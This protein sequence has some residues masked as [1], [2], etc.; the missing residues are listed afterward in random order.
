LHPGYKYTP[1][2]PG[3]KKKRQSR[4][5]KQAAAAATVAQ[6]F[7]VAPVPEVVSLTALDTNIDFGTATGVNPITAG[8][9]FIS[10]LGQFTGPMSFFGLDEAGLAVDSELHDAESLRQ[11]GLQ[12][13][14]E[15]AFAATHP[16]AQVAGDTFAFRVGADGDVTLPSI[17]SD[18]Y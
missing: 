5:A 16:F 4:K 7:D 9:E 1:R 12:I 10:D 15:A 11:F 3:E 8:I 2:K 6:S 13:E 17:N 14:L 18:D